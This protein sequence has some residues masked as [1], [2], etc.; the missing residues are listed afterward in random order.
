MDDDHEPVFRKSRW[1]T[2]RY[3]YNPRNPIGLALIVGTLVL[4]GVMLL[5]MENRA[6]PFAPPSG[7]TWSPPPETW[8]APAWPSAPAPP[9][10]TTP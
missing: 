9:T 10:V 6:G 3:T 2:N 7:P 1:G 5:L 8:P 4:T